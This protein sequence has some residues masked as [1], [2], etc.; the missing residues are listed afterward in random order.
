MKLLI[1]VCASLLLIVWPLRLEALVGTRQGTT[2]Y[3]VSVPTPPGTL[4]DIGGQRLHLNC[5]GSGSPTVLLESG[6]GDVSVIWSLVQPGVSAFTRICSYDR[7]GYA[8]SDPGTRPRTF[9]QL[10]LE[11]P[12]ALDRMQIGP[13]CVLVGESSGALVIRAFAARS[14]SEVSG[15]VMVDAVHED[16]YVVYGGQPHRIRDSAKG[17]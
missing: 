2:T 9:A 5:A 16:Q 15:M 10:A 12:T 14:R 3:N 1:L 4:V 13:P 6:T 8:W 7:G 11:L 17:L